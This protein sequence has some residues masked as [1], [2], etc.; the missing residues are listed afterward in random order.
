MRLGGFGPEDQ[1]DDEEESDEDGSEDGEVLAR[2]KGDVGD[3]SRARE[4]ALEEDG[5]ED[6]AVVVSG[7]RPLSLWLTSPNHWDHRR[8][9]HAGRWR[10]CPVKSS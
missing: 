10:G 5:A 3:V 7:H 9:S 8:I 6:S 1:H 2:Q 4:D